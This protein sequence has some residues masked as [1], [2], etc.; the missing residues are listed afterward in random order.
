MSNKVA[1]P[2]IDQNVVYDAFLTAPSHPWSVNKYDRQ[3]LYV[4]CNQFAIFDCGEYGRLVIYANQWVYFPLAQGTKITLLV[5]LYSV[6]LHFLASDIFLDQIGNQATGLFSYERALQGFSYT[7][8]FVATTGNNHY[9]A[10][11]MTAQAATANIVLDRVNVVLLAAATAVKLNQIETATIDSNL[12]TFGTILNH[13]TDGVNAVGNVTSAATVQHGETTA[14][15]GHGS[16]HGNTAVGPV[17]LLTTDT[18][19]IPRGG[20]GTLAVYVLLP[21]SGNQACINLMWHE[22]L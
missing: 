1:N 3:H 21:T 9:I 19:I 5:P 16:I 11:E 6:T 15:I 10:V 18:R 14:E 17:E 20:N 4:F 12:S 2:F 13:R 7:T 8:G 22:E